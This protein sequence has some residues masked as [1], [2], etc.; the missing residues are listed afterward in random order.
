MRS[1]PT[2]LCAAL[3]LGGL[4]SGCGD[5]TDTPADAVMTQTA[6]A[7]AAPLSYD[8]LPKLPLDVSDVVI[9]DTW[10]P[11]GGAGVAVEDEATPRPVE[12]LSRMIRDRV[13]ASGGTGR[14][15]VTIEDASLTRL[16]G[17]IVGS[18]AVQVALQGGTGDTPP[19]V[20]ASVSGTRTLSSD[21]S[22]QATADALVRQLMDRMNVELEYQIR[23]QLA[24]H[25]GG[26]AT[27]VP[28]A[29]QSEDLTPPA[30]AVAAPRPDINPPTDAA[31]VNLAPSVAP[32]DPGVAPPS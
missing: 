21:G 23:H 22:E 11:Q 16:P 30:G 8:Y 1:H 19:P 20:V 15:A 3:L 6:H 17:Q 5:D 27:P 12:A 25:T 28:P 32:A 7:P 26:A 13:I 10:T 9:D 14:A 4:L 18:F 29:V 24:G 31:P 2:A